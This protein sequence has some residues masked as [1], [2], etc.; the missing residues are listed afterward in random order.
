MTAQVIE[1]G[2]AVSF[3]ELGKRVFN[4]FICGGGFSVSSLCWV[5]YAYYMGCFLGLESFDLSYE[6]LSFQT[7]SLLFS[8]R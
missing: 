8:C 6:N 4:R 5:V 3:A 2:G 1:H 7:S